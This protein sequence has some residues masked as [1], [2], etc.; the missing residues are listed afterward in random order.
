[1]RAHP[2][3]LRPRRVFFARG[4]LPSPPM[5]ARSRSRSR[6][7]PAAAFAGSLRLGTA[8]ALGALATLAPA[9]E[10]ARETLD[11]RFTVE[12]ITGP[13]RFLADDLLEGRGVGTRGDALSR[14]YLAS[15]MEM[16]G[17]EPGG[18]DGSWEQSV[19]I[20]GIQAEV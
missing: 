4:R 1:T 19:P 20:L 17:L 8:A 18:A 10:P 12:S 15:Q 7:S 2:A 11:A 13:L 14:L 9:Q 6:P 5:D 3:G 16:F